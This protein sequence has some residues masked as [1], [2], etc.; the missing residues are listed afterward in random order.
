MEVVVHIKNVYGNIMLKFIKNEIKY[1]EFIRKL[2]NDSRVQDG[3]IDE[4]PHITPEQQIK[5]MEIYKDNFYICLGFGGHG[6]KPIPVGYIRQIDGDIG[7]CTD[8]TYQGRG[9]A[10]FMINELMK[11]HPECFAKI[12]LDNVASIRAFEKA[13]FRKKYYLMEKD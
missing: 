5:Y 7:L 6:I 13:G 10:T 9:I 11:L 8:P 2:R 4:L 1:F 3:F 12:K